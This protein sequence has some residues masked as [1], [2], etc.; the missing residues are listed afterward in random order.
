MRRLRPR[1]PAL[2]DVELKSLHGLETVGVVEDPL[3]ADGVR[4]AGG[5]SSLGTIAQ[6]QELSS[7]HT[8]TNLELRL[9]FW[10]RC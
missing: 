5:V 1:C 7:R 10:R 6:S 8:A 2:D 3:A 4:V 9:F